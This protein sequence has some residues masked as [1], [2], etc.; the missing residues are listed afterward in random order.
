MARH[1]GAKGHPK[2]GPGMESRHH[3]ERASERDTSGHGEKAIE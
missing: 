3:R 2:V 1:A